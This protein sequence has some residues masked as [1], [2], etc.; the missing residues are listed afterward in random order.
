[1]SNGSRNRN[2]LFIIG[3]LVLTNLA[4]LA[5]FLWYKKPAEYKGGEGGREGWMT[6]L[7]KKDVGFDDQQ[8]AL[9]DS[10]KTQQRATIKPMFEQMRKAKENMFRL[11]SDPTANDSLVQQAS[12][13]IA[14]RQKELDLLTFAHFKKV[15][16]ICKSEQLA[17]YDSMVQRMFRRMGRSPRKPE[18]SKEEKTN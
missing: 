18:G 2:L 5:Y 7:L 10:L 11:L 1:M 14:H 16:A 17:R 3:I 12:E 15:R 6:G 4:V 13:E 8:I 9:Y